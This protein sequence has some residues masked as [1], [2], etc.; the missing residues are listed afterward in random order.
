[1]NELETAKKNIEINYLYKK[2]KSQDY[3]TETLG[4]WWAS[5]RFRLLF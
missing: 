1:M 4:F 3:A 5:I 2:E